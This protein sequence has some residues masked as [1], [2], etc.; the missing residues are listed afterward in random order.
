MEIQNLERRNSEYALFESQ[1]ELELQDDS[2]LRKANQS[3]LNVREFICVANWRWRTIVI[4]DAMQEVAEK[5]KNFKRRCYQEENT[6]KTTKI[7]RISYA[8][9]AGITNSESILLRSWFTERLWR[10]YVPH[11][12]PIT[13]IS[14]KPSHEV[15]MPRN[16][17]E[18][19]SILGN[20]FWSSTWSTRSWWITQWF[21]NFGNTIGNPWWC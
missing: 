5:L 11:Q 10:T 17:R 19:V 14:R 1:R 9:W 7:G 21:Q 4:K 12:A 18:N 2:Y 16:T 15:G 8:A 3:K 13:S 20:V 6:E